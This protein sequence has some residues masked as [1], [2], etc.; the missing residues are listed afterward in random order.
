MPIQSDIGSHIRGIFFTTHLQDLKFRLDATNRRSQ[1]CK[2][3]FTEEESMMGGKMKWHG[4]RLKE[5]C[6]EYGQSMS[7]IAADMAVSRPTLYSWFEEK[8]PRGHQLLKLCDKLDIQPEALFSEDDGQVSIPVHRTQSHVEVSAKHQDS[9]LAIAKDFE[10]FFKDIRQ[11]ELVPV[12]RTNSY[13]RAHIR[14]TA[15]KLRILAGIADGDPCL[16]ENAFQ[17]LK[18]L[19][20]YVVL[21]PFPE[22]HSGYA[23]F[24]QIAGH[25]VVFVNRH[26]NKLDLTFVLL[27]EAVH[28]AMDES[29]EVSEDVETFCDQV[30]SSVQFPPLYIEL[31]SNLIHG[32][33]SR[34]ERRIIKQF[35]TKNEHAIYGITKVLFPDNKTR[36]DAAARADENLRK[37]FPTIDDTL[38]RNDECSVFIQAYGELSEL[39]L[40]L[41][42]EQ[43]PHLSERR[44]GELLG[45]ESELDASQIKNRLIKLR[46]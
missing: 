24:S 1:Y 15:D 20:C 43:L 39:F 36:K 16:L 23:F 10:A 38:F 2:D 37:H 35:A 5:L 9:S 29:A 18:A 4:D 19:S 44:V 22:D 6:N 12:I 8:V 7:Q 46:M 34:E 32:V 42:T 21:L 3:F 45:L 31:V 33:E 27:H 26:A 17:L 13:D 25:R 40:H 28:A 11:A 41:V 30:A 14:S